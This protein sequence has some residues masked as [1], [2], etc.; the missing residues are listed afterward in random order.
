MSRWRKQLADNMPN[1][2]AHEGHWDGVYRHQAADGSLIDEHRV[3]THCEF[4]DAGEYAYI[5]HN[6][7]IWPNGATAKYEFGGTY[8]D[9]KIYWE[10]DRFSGYGWDSEGLL[11]LRLDRKD[12]PDERYTEMI[13]IADDGQS[14]ARTWQWF[15]NGVPYKRTLCDEK[16]VG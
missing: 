5:Q 2:L 14:R 4:P 6:E 15:R 7:L 10:T 11:L 8:R 1:M 9:G 16:R 13:E 12:A 3:L